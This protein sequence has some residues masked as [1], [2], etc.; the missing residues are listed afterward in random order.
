CTSFPSAVGDFVL[1]TLG[2]SAALVALGLADGAPARAADYQVIHNF[3]GPTTDGSTPYGSL[4][5]SGSGLYGMTSLG[6]GSNNGT[7]FQVETDGSDFQVLHT[8]TGGSDGKWPFD[9]L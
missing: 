3:T 4:I 7:V 2:L 5:Q 1:R 8:F 9:S 6:G